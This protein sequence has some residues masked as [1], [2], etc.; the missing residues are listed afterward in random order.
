MIIL[1]LLFRKEWK[2]LI[3]ILSLTVVHLDTD[4]ATQ[5]K[6]KYILYIYIAFAQSLEVLL[7]WDFFKS[8]NEE[9]ITIYIKKFSKQSLK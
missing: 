8:Q 6:V 2:V 3:I 7:F 9:P 1:M 4:I 5:K